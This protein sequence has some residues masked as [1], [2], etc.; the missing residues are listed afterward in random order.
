MDGETWVRKLIID[1]DVCSEMIK[2]RAPLG[3]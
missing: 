2:P 1:I 3:A